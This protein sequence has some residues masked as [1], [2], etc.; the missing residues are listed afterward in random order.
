M[1]ERDVSRNQDTENVQTFVKALLRDVEALER[2]LEGDMFETGIRRI[3]A[4]QEMFLVDPDFF[5]API[6][7]IVL[8]DI[9]SPLIGTELARFNLEANLTPRV[10][11][12][13]CLH[14]IEE[15]LRELLELAAWSARAH[16]ADVMITGILPTLDRSH[17]G[18]EN[19]A[20]NPRYLELNNAIA[21]ARG[22][23]FTID[24]EGLDEL[25]MT[26]DNVLLEA[27]NTS[28]QLHFQVAPAEFSNL[29]NLAQLVT[30][31]LL[32]ASV[33][34]PVFAKKR[35]WKETRIA[36]FQ[37]SVDPRSEAHRTR[38]HQTRVTFGES[39]LND[40]VLEMI[41][42]DI[43]RYRVLLVKKIEEDPMQVLDDGGIPALHALTLHNG[44]VYRWNRFCYGRGDGIPHLRI[45]NRVLPAGPTVNDEMANAAFYYGMMS[46]LSNTYSDVRDVFSFDDVKR[47]FFAAAQHGLKAQF[48]WEKGKSYTAEDLIL[49]ELIPAAR[50][51]LEASGIDRR[52]IDRYLPIIEERVKSGRTGSQWMLDSLANMGTDGTT[53]LRFRTLTRA[54]LARQRRSQPVHTWE[55]A[56]LEEVN[57]WRFG[58]LTVKQV[59]NTE[60]YTVHPEDVIEMVANLMD[61]NNLRYVPVENEN[62]ELLGL[63]THRSLLRLVGKP[64]TTQLTAGDLMI[65]KLVTVTP[66]TSTP[67][68]IRIMRDQKIGCLPVVEGKHL[69]GTLTDRDFLPLSQKLVDELLGLNVKRREA[70]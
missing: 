7:D 43:A 36:L 1:G 21:R 5:P 32:A 29:Y 64:N 10:F 48:T 42:E 49:Q 47:N 68:A 52:D 40:S 20:P 22:G 26:H 24:I 62:G 65:S 37:H 58:F 69:V 23:T 31:P 34:S 15:E 11:G 33:N 19:I 30:G 14:D 8:E 50:H 54:I 60:L 57:D 35:L 28:F 6:A 16:H 46:A 13:S 2:M 67:E 56:N 27:C 53:D 59:M 63:V 25:Q 70:K 18:L 41:R 55:L 3:G 38:G 51:G 12:G 61:W 66:D 39:W 45:E 44:T 17:L 9:D 4:E